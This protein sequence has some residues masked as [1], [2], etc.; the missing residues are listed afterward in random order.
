M[1]ENAEKFRALDPAEL[2]KQLREGAE[3]LFR[4]RF[5]MS[6]GQMDGI[7]KVRTLRK[8]RA[9]ILTVLKEKGMAPSAAAAAPVPLVTKTTK[10]A[11]PKVAAKA[12]AKNAAPKK[13][14]KPAAAKTAPKKAR[15]K[16]E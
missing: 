14:A 10:K 13:A 6:M 4:L 2:D 8:E 12:G 3:Q 15:K 1:K 5:Q 11:A 9:R 7:K 16:G